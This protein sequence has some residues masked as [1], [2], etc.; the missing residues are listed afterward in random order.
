MF[1]WQFVAFFMTSGGGATNEMPAEGSALY[2]HFI[3][4]VEKRGQR[5]G[6]QARQVFKDELARNWSFYANNPSCISN[7][8]SNILDAAA[9]RGEQREELRSIRQQELENG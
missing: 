3:A 8:Q 7:A 4:S 9:R 1:K 6:S 2:A 5:L